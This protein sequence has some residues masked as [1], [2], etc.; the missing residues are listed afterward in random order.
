MTFGLNSGWSGAR[1]RHA[2]T[3]FKPDRLCGGPAGNA[4]KVNETKFLPSGYWR[5]RRS[6]K[7]YR[8][9]ADPE[10]ELTGELEIERFGGAFVPRV[11]GLGDV[12][13]INWDAVMGVP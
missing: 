9:E 4:A 5:S 10:T 12:A 3:R 11:C 6:I 7:T 8:P 2:K 1:L 13:S